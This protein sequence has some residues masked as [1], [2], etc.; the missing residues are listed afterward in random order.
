[1]RDIFSLK[2]EYLKKLNLIPSK[3]VLLRFLCNSNLPFETI[4]RGVGFKIRITEV[5]I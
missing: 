4:V 1:M 5:R 2:K 3:S